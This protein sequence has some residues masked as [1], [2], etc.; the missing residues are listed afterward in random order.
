MSFNNIKMLREQKID[1]DNIIINANKLVF[2]YA[3][4]IKTYI[5]METRIL[6]QFKT[7]A[8]LST[9]KD[10]QSQLYDNN[11]EYRFWLNFRNYIIHCDF[12]YHKFTETIYTDP[13]VICTKNHLL[14]FN[15]WKHSK[16]DIIKMS[17]ETDLP[18]MVNTMSSL[19]LVL[20]INFFSFFGNEIIHAISVLG[21][22]CRSYKVK[23]P[24]IMKTQVEHSYENAQLQPL[25]IKE[26]KH[27]F[28]TL[29]DNPHVTINIIK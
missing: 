13:K 4:S 9:F 10:L 25:P 21:E 12:P 3:S 26:L 22:F 24:I 5:D 23:N 20:Y 2:N 17:D 8:E 19:I 15:N 27:A 7:D 1:I 11:L 6:T 28:K 29:S 14:E 18:S 16:A